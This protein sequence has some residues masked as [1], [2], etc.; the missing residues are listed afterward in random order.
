M[1]VVNWWCGAMCG[2]LQINVMLS[3]LQYIVMQATLFRFL[4]FSGQPLKKFCI[5][6]LH[7]FCLAC[8]YSFWQYLMYCLLLT[9]KNWIFFSIER[10]KRICILFVCQKWKREEMN[11]IT[12]EWV[13]FWSHIAR[14]YSFDGINDNNHNDCVCVWKIIILNFACD[15][16]CGCC[17]CYFCYCF[18]RFCCRSGR[19]LLLWHWL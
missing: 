3:H 13:K 15:F 6:L 4:S 9:R 5:F 8:W 1:D 18:N 12:L 17:C 10:W 11:E 19:T 16:F 14:I 7:V 2:C